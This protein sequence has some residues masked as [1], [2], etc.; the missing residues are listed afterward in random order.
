MR[1]EVDACMGCEVPGYPCNRRCTAIEI[2]CDRCGYEI[3]P[4]GI[5]LDEGL[6]YQGKDYHA[7]CLIDLLK[8]EKMIEEI[9]PDEEG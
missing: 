1:R 6:K 2:V 7:E 3:E 8:E 4:D 5:G 9:L